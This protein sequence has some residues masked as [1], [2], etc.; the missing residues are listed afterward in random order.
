MLD[1][2]EERNHMTIQNWLR[3][4]AAADPANRNKYIEAADEMD[5]LSNIEEL[6]RNATSPTATIREAFESVDSLSETVRQ[7]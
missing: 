6:A 5:R 3:M 2:R 7:Q 1:P 4:M